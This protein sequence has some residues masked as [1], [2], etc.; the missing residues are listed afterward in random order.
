VAIDRD[1][2]RDLLAQSL[3]TTREFDELIRTRLRS[4]GSG[5]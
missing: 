5:S 2:F 4:A 1:T 3:G